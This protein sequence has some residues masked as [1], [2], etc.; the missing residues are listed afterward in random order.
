MLLKSK[1]RKSIPG[2]KQANK[3]KTREKERGE[4]K[5][6]AEPLI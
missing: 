6:A 3:R 5:E 1:G 2:K 4:H